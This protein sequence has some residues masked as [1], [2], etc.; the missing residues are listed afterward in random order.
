M[1]DNSLVHYFR[2]PQ[3]RLVVLTFGFALI[4]SAFLIGFS[5][6]KLDSTEYGLQYDVNAKKLD[7]TVKEGGLHAGP[8]GF[9][10]VKFPS[11]YIST[12]IP[13]DVT[14]GKDDWERSQEHDRLGMCVS[15]DGLRVKLEVEIQY[16]MPREFVA[17][18]TRKYR[19]LDR[20]SK[21]VETMAV[22]AVQKGCSMFYTSSFQNERGAIQGVM[23]EALTLKLEAVYARAVGLQLAFVELPLEYGTAVA[24]KQSA[25]EDI[26]LAVNQREQQVTLAETVLQS[27]MQESK[28]INDTATNEKNLMV[29]EASLKAEGLL[30][31]YETEARVCKKM[32]DSLGLTTEG[33]LGYMGNRALQASNGGITF[34]MT[35]PAKSSYRDSGVEASLG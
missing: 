18:A 17:P 16:Q 9:R 11:T 22:S 19:T 30:V 13:H 1:E 14:T 20:W 3:R 34:S 21:I 28:Q 23:E 2:K 24:A 25:A 12:K 6:K 33:V 26:G 27:A 29:A 31:A 7:G 4:V 32:R 35:E 5:L 10:F 8:P 15:R